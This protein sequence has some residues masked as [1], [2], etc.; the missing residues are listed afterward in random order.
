MAM[1][2]ADALNAIATVATEERNQVLAF[3]LFTPD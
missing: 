1:S 3:I 2:A